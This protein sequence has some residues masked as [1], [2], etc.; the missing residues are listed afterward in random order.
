[1]T[2]HLT[3]TA[4]I[5]LM[6]C[7]MLFSCKKDTPLCTDD[8]AFCSFINNQNYDA[9]GPI[10][11]DFLSDLSADEPETSL[12]LLVDWLECIS[13]VD[14][15]SLICNSCILTLPAQSELSVDYLSNGQTVTLVMDISMGDTLTFIRHH[16]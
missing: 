11:D 8:E 6:I 13:C 1:M 2:R 5:F 14:N 10:I 7:M 4:G 15:V 3:F 12:N 16:E 9:T